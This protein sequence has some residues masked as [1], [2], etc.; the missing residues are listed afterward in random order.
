MSNK[1]GEK[2]FL[3]SSSKEKHT[4]D[5]VQVLVEKPQADSGHD[6]RQ[7]PLMM[8]SPPCPLKSTFQAAVQSPALSVRAIKWAILHDSY[9]IY[10]VEVAEGD[11]SGCCKQSLNAANRRRYR[12]Q[13]C[14]YSRWT[15]KIFWVATVTLRSLSSLFYFIV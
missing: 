15:I 11:P 12:L 14:L 8:W 5:N 7:C 2:C 13:E 4:D 9:Q 3:T 10:A 1:S 6:S